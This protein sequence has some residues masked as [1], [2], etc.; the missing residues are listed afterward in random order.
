MEL[1]KNIQGGGEEGVMNT[2]K[3]QQHT[4]KTGEGG[5]R[6]ALVTSNRKFRMK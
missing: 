3:Q 4:N 5:G 1:I 6:S 2:P